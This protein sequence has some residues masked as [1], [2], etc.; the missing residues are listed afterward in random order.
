MTLDPA[1][2]QYLR[3][4][5]G[6]DRVL[7]PEPS[8]GGTDAGL[9]DLGSELIVRGNPRTASLVV[10]WCREDGSGPEAK[11]LASKMI[12]AMKISDERIAWLE[13][14]G[15]GTSTED[16]VRQSIA[17]FPAGGRTALLAFGPEAG[18]AILG[19]ESEPGEWQALPTGAK[20]MA[21]FSPEDLLAS[22]ERK[23]QA[24]AHLQLVMK[25]LA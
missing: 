20:V 23:K 2:I 21:T 14:T 16:E 4:V 11:E 7:R 5:L 17:A 25:A 3:D 8:P 12:A 6:V 9:A 18:A 10:V 24:W 1:Q 13:W 22:P 19:H 15:S